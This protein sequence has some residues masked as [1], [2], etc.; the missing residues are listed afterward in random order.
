MYE[1]NIPWIRPLMRAVGRLSDKHLRNHAGNPAD[2]QFS[3]L[4]G[5]PAC[6]NAVHIVLESAA[7]NNARSLCHHNIYLPYK[8]HVCRHAPPCLPKTSWDFDSLEVLIDRLKKHAIQLY[9]QPVGPCYFEGCDWRH[10]G[11][12]NRKLLI[13]MINN[14]TD[15]GGHIPPMIPTTMGY[16]YRN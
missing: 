14:H 13:H 3:H 11:K 2:I 6:A 8:H 12:P 9:N 7:D 4:C 10:D 15:A 1:D 16:K 5:N